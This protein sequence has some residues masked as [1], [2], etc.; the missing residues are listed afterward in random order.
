MNTH[1]VRVGDRDVVIETGRLAAQA[2]GAALVRLGD[3]VVLVTAVAD[4]APRVGGDFFP[5]TVEYAERAAAG[6]RIPGQRNRR[7]GRPDEREILCA[8]LIDRAVRPL[9]PGAFRAET[10]IIAT[11]LSADPDVEPAPL[12][13]L[14]ASAALRLSDIPW[15]GPVAALRL[16][17]LDRQWVTFP[18]PRERAAAELDIVVAVGPN[19]LLMVEGA[20]REAREALIV[21][22]LVTAQALAAPL[23]DVQQTGLA[24]ESRP[25]RSLAGVPQFEPLLASL[26]GFAPRLE[27][28]WLRPAKAERR[29][30]RAAVRGEML[31]AALPSVPDSPALAEQACNA[32]ER[33]AARRLLLDGRRFDGRGTTEVRPIGSEVGLLPRC[34]G[35]ALFSRGET[36]A[37]ATCTLGVG[38]DALTVEDLHGREER[39]F[40]LHYNFPPF[41]VG[42][43]RPLRGTGRREFGHGALA[44]RALLPVLP[45]ADR[46]PYVV[47]VVS[48]ILA[49]NGSSSMASVCAGCLAMLDAGVPLLRPVA[50][51]AMGLVS[52][53]SRIV[54]LTDI[55]GDEDH[56]GDMDFKVAG[57]EE[58]ITAVQMDIKIAGL[59]ADVLSNA[60][61]QARDAR[62][63][64]LAC[65]AE[66]LATPR[67]ELSPQAPRLLSMRIRAD[68]KADVIGPGGSRIRQIQD[69]TGAT[70]EL[71]DDGLVQV[72]APD[73]GAARAAL[74][75]IES[76]VREA[77]VGALYRARVAKVLPSVAFVELFPGTE[78]VLPISE[79]APERIAQVSDVLRE[80]SFV[81]VRVLGVDRQ[82]RIRASRKAALDAA[83]EEVPDYH[84]DPWT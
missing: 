50:G 78:A 76:L 25:K 7:E 28:A 22:A 68:R 1:S 37:L 65:M 6:G 13:M 64:I 40:F 72:A 71:R 80:G 53:G 48:D 27:E 11:V 67:A 33:D 58:G 54:V 44:T 79:V 24:P 42:E 82:G 26:A 30:A 21:E 73:L 17:R 56:L 32:L 52:D 55:L 61:S 36:Q 12:A 4:E 81:A 3:T 15:E 23:L 69:D 38:R 29:R 51:V 16:A 2:N 20:G 41:S 77:E 60:L 59:A 43:V 10:Q 74:S 14:G 5:L 19:G 35:S 84:A 18:T 9:F 63:H 47:R 66:T 75:R 49:S 62:L 46:F 57:T 39:R 34:H 8:R 83:A 31:A 45:E 70:V